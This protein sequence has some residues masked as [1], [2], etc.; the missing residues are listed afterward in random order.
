[1]RGFVERV[2]LYF[3]RHRLVFGA[4]LCAVVG[5][6][7][8]A[9]CHVRFSEDIGKF[10][11]KDA[12]NERADRAFRLFSTSNRVMVYVSM[13]DSSPAD[14]PLLEQ[15]AAEF[16]EALRS[17]DSSGYTSD[18]FLN[19][20]PERVL[21]TM[22]F[23][24]ANLP[25]YLEPEDYKRIDSVWSDSALARVMLTDRNQ[26]MSPMGGFSQEIV[27]RDPLH[28]SSPVLNKLNALRPSEGEN[29]R[30]GYL[31][32]KEG[33]AIMVP[34]SSSLPS[35]ETQKNKLWI[36]SIGEAA[37]SVMD[38]YE[39]RVNVSYIG[40]AVISVGNADQIKRD[41]IWSTVIALSLIVILLALFYRDVRAILL[42][43]FSIAFGSLF[44]LAFMALLKGDVSV[45]AIGIGSVIVGIAVNYPL[46]FLAHLKEGHTRQQA[47]RDIVDPLV[48]GNI[49]TVGAFL[50]LLFIRSEAMR[51][52]GL[53]AALLLVGTILFV[54]FVLPHFFA[55]KLFKGRTG[56]KLMFGKIANVQ[57]EKNKVAVCLIVLLTFPLLYFSTK[58]QFETDMNAINYMTP[59]QRVR[60]AKL[61]SETESGLSKSFCVAEGGTMDEALRRYESVRGSMDSLLSAGTISKVTG[62]SLFLPSKEMQERRATVWNDYWTN[63]PMAADMIRKQ[64]VAAGFAAEA[65][66]PFLTMVGKRYG[67][68]EEDH[69]EPI[70]RS[71]A[72]SYVMEDDGRWYVYSI[73]E[74][75]QDASEVVA[76]SFAGR[77]ES[78][79][80]FDGRSMLNKLVDTLS[81]DFN[82][83]LFLCGFIVFL[84]LLISFGRS[85]L[86]LLAFVPLTVGWVWILG[87]M[88]ILDMR[89]NIVNIILATFI[90]G[91]GDD[92]TI[93]V[94]EGLMH[95]YAYGK[96]VLA[97]YK[98]SV[99]L[100]ALIMFIGIGTLIIAKHP[101]MRS[102]AEVTIV[103]MFTVI[104]MAYF[105]PPLI[106]NWLTKSKDKNRLMPITL[107]NL[108]LTIG[109][110]AV[111]FVG[112]IYMSL[113]G[114]IV[115]T[116]GGKTENHKAFYHRRLCGIF[117]VLVKLMP[118]VEC[119]VH[120]PEGETL[121]RP[122]IMICNHQSHLD[123]L[124]TLILSPKIVC[125]T[126]KWVWNCPFY[127][128]IIRYAE[129]LP[130]SDGLEQ[131]EEELKTAI[132]RGYSILIF[133][134]GTRSEDCSILRFHKGAF[135]LAERF[136]VDIIPVMIHGIGHFFP[137][138]EFLLRKGRVDVKFLPRISPEH[139]FR[140]EVK[141]LKSAQLTQHYYEEEYERMAAEIETPA[142]FA[143]LVMHNYIYKGRAVERNARRV[144]KSID[145]LSAR[146]SELP[147]E[148]EISLQE[149]EQGEFSLLAALTKKRLSIVSEIA[150]EE[151]FLLADH[152]ASKPGNLTYRL[153]SRK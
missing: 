11:P 96:K 102:L 147:D 64:A 103:G 140:K 135:H 110:F 80:F 107:K 136:N 77:D 133:P 7:A 120:N 141:S 86:A 18:V 129:F 44:G 17:A 19:A 153:T 152:C 30:N 62:I 121:D 23:V 35:S 15:A 29:M 65:F 51:D 5:L 53:F 78:L 22:D 27:L 139:S 112:T 3:R 42:I 149:E 12:R 98:N 13:A 91:Q 49:T 84:F 9:V 123:L 60:M 43:L 50:S 47:M 63:H 146:I 113:L 46:H 79:S 114:F 48:T 2:F 66:D 126:N 97:S 33:R 31:L 21:E 10:L 37:R 105:F 39:G 45:I 145:S 59:D 134:E 116:V 115:L 87:L 4:S 128:W 151:R 101:A 32:D 16:S 142:Y 100:S 8:V 138:K 130:V 93:F 92:Y 104:L 148:G 125:L 83:V 73:M 28:L 25:Y 57:F 132:D 82:N 70:L 118:G 88:G 38:K 106:F 89:F 56:G 6:L 52:M 54:L 36:A 74:H 26:L 109:C 85:E 117:R 108:L 14:F 150:D 34:V 20:D 61:T 1:M 24:L 99:M 143:D 58:T 67:V 76:A 68:A 137:K 71:L 111:F 119:H 55:D 131:H 144:L 75:E 72:K 124:Y 40:P 81:S 122:G 94:T 90:F 127:G 95:E 69:F 41:T